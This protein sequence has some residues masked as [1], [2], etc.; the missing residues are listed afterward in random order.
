MSFRPVVLLVSV[1]RANR[2]DIQKCLGLDAAVANDFEA[3]IQVCPF[4]RAA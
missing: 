2:G 1:P 3:K 4:L